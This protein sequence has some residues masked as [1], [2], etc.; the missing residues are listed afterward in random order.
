MTAAI[1]AAD[2][3]AVRSDSAIDVSRRVRV[4]DCISDV[5]SSADAAA[6][7]SRVAAHGAVDNHHT[8][9]AA[10]HD[11][12]AV[13]ASR[14][15]ADRAVNDGQTRIATSDATAIGK[16]EVTTDRAVDNGEVPRRFPPAMYV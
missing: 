11:S 10:A 5:H 14:V 1:I 7:S 2:V 12:A 8:E 15:A 3:V 4:Q 9:T 13:S 16:G 6:S